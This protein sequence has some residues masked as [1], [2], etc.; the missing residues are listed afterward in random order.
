M[1]KQELLIKILTSMGCVLLMTESPATASA[2]WDDD[3]EEESSSSSCSSQS[4][5]RKRERSE[6][7]RALTEMQSSPTLGSTILGSEESLDEPAAER[8]QRERD[9]FE[10]QVYAIPT[11]DATFKYVMSHNDVARSFLRSFALDSSISVVETLNEHLVPFKEFQM[12]REVVHDKK[13]QRF[14]A[15]MNQLLSEEEERE[16]EVSIGDGVQGRS[17]V[18]GGGRFIKSMASI[19]GDILKCYPKP[20]RN[21]QVDYVCLVDNSYYAIVEVQVV[22]YAFWDQ[23]ALVYAAS[24]YA[25]QLK[26]GDGFKNVK[27]VICIN[28]LGGANDKEG[29]KEDREFKH[30]SMKDQNNM[31]LEKGIEILQYPLH[32]EETLRK[33]LER[34]AAGPARIEFS[35][36]W[37]FFEHAHKKSEETVAQLRTPEVREAYKLIKTTT[38]PQEIWN[39]Y[40]HQKEEMF[41]VYKEHTEKL[42]NRG[43]E[44]GRMQGLEEGRIQ[45][46]EEGRVQGLEEARKELKRAMALRLIH[47][48]L[49]EEQVSE[50]TNLSSEELQTLTELQ[51]NSISED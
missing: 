26:E 50:V 31:I 18:R 1:Y 11:F 17:L 33:A 10:G 29:W 19:Y 21:S 8:I 13:S 35:E 20:S 5:I 25:R 6:I 22:P 24:L 36:W 42:V 51:I 40:I 44:E 16:I 43:R 4:N 15:K 41:E 9:R 30:Y 27:K 28:I 12:A 2:L 34:I 14:M 49:N 47:F 38:L 46:L 23:R 37:D 32:R 39:Q 45:G 3:S 48:G 7:S